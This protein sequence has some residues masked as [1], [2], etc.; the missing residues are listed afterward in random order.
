MSYLIL[1]ISLLDAHNPRE[2]QQQLSGPLHEQASSLCLEI[3]LFTH[4]QA[5]SCSDLFIAIS[6]SFL[7]MPPHAL[8]YS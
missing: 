3:S 6:H 2:A 1:Y 8:T 7:L 5:F 4:A